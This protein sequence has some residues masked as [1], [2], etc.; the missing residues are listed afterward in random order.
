VLLQDYHLY[1][2]RDHTRRAAGRVAAALQPH[3]WPAVDSWCAAPGLRRA[4]CE[5]LLANDI[6]G[7][8]TDRS[9]PTSRPASTPSCATRR[10]TPTAAH[11]AGAAG[12][13]GCAPTQSDGADALS[14]S[15][16]RPVAEA[17]RAELRVRSNEPPAAP[18]R[19]RRPAEPSKNA[20]RGFVRLEP[21]CGAGPAAPIRA[22]GDRFGQPGRRGRLRAT[23]PPAV[24][25]WSPG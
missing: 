3:P 24:L 2:A 16:A 8:Q 13:S 25:R 19:A 17:R 1:L 15:A 4:I 23:T 12:R 20:L 7:P 10:W 14:R 21:F 22:P 11:G 18:H 5:G 9:R 6:V